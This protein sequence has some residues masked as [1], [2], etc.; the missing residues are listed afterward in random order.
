[1]HSL[2]F[3]ITNKVFNWVNRKQLNILRTFWHICD[4][5]LLLT[6][7]DSALNVAEQFM[8]N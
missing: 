4:F 8:L 2:D 6:E 3:C 7:D 1:M 5:I